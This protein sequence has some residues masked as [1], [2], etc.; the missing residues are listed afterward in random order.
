MSSPEYRYEDLPENFKIFARSNE[1]ISHSSA[2]AIEE[3]VT[4]ERPVLE[5]YEDEL[6]ALSRQ[7]AEKKRLLAR[8]RQDLSACERIVQLSRSTSIINLP[9]EILQLIFLYSIPPSLS[10]CFLHATDYNENAPFSLIH[11]C[12]KWRTIAFKT[13]SLWTSVS[14]RSF[15]GSPMTMGE[16][17]GMKNHIKNWYERAGPLP[18]SLD[19]YMEDQTAFDPMVMP[20]LA[21][22]AFFHGFEF[23][24]LSLGSR[25]I[26]SLLRTLNEEDPWPMWNSK[27]LHRVE[28]LVLYSELHPYTFDSEEP[29]EIFSEEDFKSLRRLSL[30]IGSSLIQGTLGVFDLPWK[31]L[32]HVAITSWMQDGDFTDLLT[33]LISLQQGIFYITYDEPWNSDNGAAVEEHPHLKDLTLIHHINTFSPVPFDRYFF[34]S[35]QYFRLGAYTNFFDDDMKTFDLRNI[36]ATLINLTSLSL[37]HPSWEVSA[38]HIVDILSVTPNLLFLTV[39]VSTNYDELFNALINNGIDGKESPVVVPLL[40]DLVIDYGPLVYKLMVRIPPVRPKHFQFSS[41]VFSEMVKVRWKGEVAGSIQTSQ[42]KKASVFLSGLYESCLEGVQ[43]SLE[44]EVKE[45]FELTLGFV[46]CVQTWEDPMDRKITHW[47]EGLVLPES[48]DCCGRCL[49]EKELEDLE[50]YE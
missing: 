18:K 15:E 17:L 30:R 20:G 45:G 4:K 7:L 22:C 12:R 2:S 48:S 10:A 23:T 25:D 14:I 3:Y 9:T 34:P 49:M 27:I 42:L 31:N 1:A 11:V 35:L 41:G 19:F 44:E 33:D 29:I 8:K 24:N 32:T 39:G 13:P 37:W 46:D 28:S 47:H 38:S 36:Q 16:N 6:K 5:Q 26:N 43:D 21:D 40:E 50:I